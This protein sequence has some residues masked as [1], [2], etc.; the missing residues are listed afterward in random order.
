VN[1]ERHAIIRSAEVRYQAGA[2][3]DGDVGAAVCRLFTAEPF[4]SARLEQVATTTN[5]PIKDVAR[6]LEGL[7]RLGILDCKESPFGY[8]IYQLAVADSFLDIV[9][10]LTA[11]YSEQLDAVAISPERASLVSGDHEI[12]PPSALLAFIKL[13]T[14]LEKAK[15]DLRNTLEGGVTQMPEERIRECKEAGINKVSYEIRTGKPVNE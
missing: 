1:E 6:A 9:E 10:R 3:F 11:F 12:I 15:Q 4:Y 13:V 2:P 14:P 7:T 5:L 8:Q